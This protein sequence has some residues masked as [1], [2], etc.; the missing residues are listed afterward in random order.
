VHLNGLLYPLQARALRALLP[1]SCPIAA[2]HHAE[3]PRRGARGALQRWGLGAVDG[4]L[5]AARELAQT[6]LQHGLIRRSQPIY[7]IAEG[8]NWFRPRDR[9]AARAR[10]HIHGDPALLWVGRLDIN[11]DPLTVLAGFERVLARAP[12][13]RLHMIYG[14]DPLLPEVRARIAWSAALRASV[15]L[16]GKRPY[17][18]MEDYYNSADYFVLGSHH[19]GS[20]YALAEALACGVVPIVT[21]IPSFR[22]MTDGGALGALWS[23]GDAQALA[24]AIDAALRRPR[25][26][27]AA[28]AR[29]FFEARLSYPSIGRHALAAYDE[30]AARRGVR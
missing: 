14:D 18:E 12:G 10:T 26:V 20:G 15:V 21:D 1:S 23:P 22:V 25:E 30:L 27:L 17:H 28:A 13:A 11:K 8:S 6:W 7:E 24:A 4:F 9:A 16:L 2:Q 3:R 29:R 19:E 5:F